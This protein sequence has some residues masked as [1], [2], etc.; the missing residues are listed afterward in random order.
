MEPVTAPQEHRALVAKRMPETEHLGN[1]TAKPNGRCAT[2]GPTR[3]AATAFSLCSRVYFS[4]VVGGKLLRDDRMH[5]LLLVF[6]ADGRAAGDARGSIGI[7]VAYR[8]QEQPEVAYFDQQPVPG[9]LIG[10]R[11]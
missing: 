6:P 10:D 2:P 4:D 9:S 1:D 8:D 3:L 5:D 11:A 7:D